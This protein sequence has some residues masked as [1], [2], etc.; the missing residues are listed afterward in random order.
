MTDRYIRFSEVRNWQDCKRSWMNGYFLN[1]TKPEFSGEVKPSKANV[2]TYVHADLESYYNGDTAR[3]GLFHAAVPVP[4]SEMFQK[5]WDNYHRLAQVMLDG[6]GEWLDEE[7]LDQGEETLFTEKEIDLPFG[8]M[9]GDRV[10]LQMH[11]DRIVRDTDFDRIII[12]DTKTVD[13]LSKDS[14]FAIES[15][16]LT[17]TLGVQ[18]V[19]GLPVAEC[20]HN[21]L[22]RVL[23]SARATPPFYGRESIT[24][25]ATQLENHRTQ[26]AALLSEIVLGYQALERDPAAHQSV[27]PPHPTKD[28]AWRCAFLA[29]CACHDDGSDLD[30]MRQALYIQREKK[31]TSN[32]RDSD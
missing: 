31:E 19:L 32:G 8:E 7:G 14:S 11:V 30:G 4:E 16:L 29:I 9:H 10:F 23:R 21:M 2:G 5:E 18:D 26:L 25:S 6:Y 22:R 1:L 13:S 28:C 24:P 20:R 17:Y 12:E 27:A 15:Q 3:P